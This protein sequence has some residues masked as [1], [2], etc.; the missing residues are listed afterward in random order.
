[1]GQKLI[2]SQHLIDWCDQQVA[3]G[4]KLQL[5]WDGGNDSGWVYI[6]KDGVQVEYN[7]MSQEET[8]LTDIMNNELSYGSWAG[9]FSA[10]GEADYDPE[11]KSFTG[12]DSCGSDDTDFCSCKIDIV[13]PKS[14][15]F[16]SV[17]YN[18]EGED[19]YAEFAFVIKNGFIT[20]AHN[21][22]SKKIAEQLSEAVSAEIEKYESNS[23]NQE[24]RG[25]WQDEQIAFSEFVED[26]DNLIYSITELHIGTTEVEER[27]VCLKLESL[28]L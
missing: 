16:D 15:W 1:M 25:I 3:N 18:L 13:I 28:N 20:E 26:G 12:T 2:T 6:L 9:E 8:T 5:G 10:N 23:E 24:F 14:L 19:P 21:E 17:E 27:D 11:T 4:I 7:E 22:M